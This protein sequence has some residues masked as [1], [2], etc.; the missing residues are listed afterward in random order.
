MPRPQ[1]PLRPAPSSLDPEIRARKISQ[2]KR[3]K[4][5]KRRIYS[6]VKG[7]D[8]DISAGKVLRIVEIMPVEDAFNIKDFHWRLVQCLRGFA[9]VER[10][11]KIIPWTHA[12]ATHVK[13][14][15][16]LANALNATCLQLSDR[17]LRC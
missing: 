12:D 15:G 3:Q 1:K 10:W 14:L 5:L 17:D 6:N 7:L 9:V 11:A 16:T 13:Q 4:F 2:F 8:I